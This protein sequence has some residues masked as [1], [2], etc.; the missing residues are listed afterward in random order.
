LDSNIPLSTRIDPVKCL[1]RKQSFVTDKLLEELRREKDTWGERERR[2]CRD[3]VEQLVGQV[4][5]LT[6]L[7]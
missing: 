2:V 5:G 7:V 1:P 4:I 6:D 3:E